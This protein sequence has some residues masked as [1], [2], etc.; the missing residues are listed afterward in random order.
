MRVQFFVWLFTMK[1]YNELL[2]FDLQEALRSKWAM[3]LYLEL[4]LD[5]SKLDV[6]LEVFDLK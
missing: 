4:C 1:G 3:K 6:W 2:W 5:V